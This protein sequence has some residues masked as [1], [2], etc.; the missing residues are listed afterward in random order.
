MCFGFSSLG[1]R[2]A[3]W[4]GYCGSVAG[5]VRVTVALRSNMLPALL[6]NV[7]ALHLVFCK[8]SHCNER[9]CVK[10]ASLRAGLGDG[11]GRCVM[12]LWHR[13]GGGWLQGWGGTAR[14]G[15]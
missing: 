10:Q 12:E 5:R 15:E 4:L 9:S 2:A 3:W 13:D 14:A 6:G 8:A 7:G 1:S 11:G